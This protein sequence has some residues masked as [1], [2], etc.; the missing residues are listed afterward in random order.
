MIMLSKLTEVE[1]HIHD[2][3]Q[4]PSTDPLEALS[5]RSAPH[6]CY[7]CCCCCCCLLSS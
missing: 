7:F 5:L 6:C 3:D 4:M 2:A 1:A